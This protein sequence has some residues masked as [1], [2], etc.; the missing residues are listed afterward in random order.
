MHHLRAPW[1]AKVHDWC[2]GG[3]CREWYLCL[4]RLSRNPP[5]S[6][7]PVD[8]IRSLTQARQSDGR[9]SCALDSTVTHDSSARRSATAARMADFCASGAS[10]QSIISVSVRKQP[11]HR[12]PCIWQ[13]WTQGEGITVLRQPV[14]R[15]WHAQHA[16]PAR[17]GIRLISR[18]WYRSAYRDRRRNRCPAL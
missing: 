18:R 11:M 9:W 17:G 8:V 7:S 14:W 1:C 13:N 12:S 2:A 10:A 5:Y 4:P 3:L 15:G 16:N 6:I